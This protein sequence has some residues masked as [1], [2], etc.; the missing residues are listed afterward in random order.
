[1]MREPVIQVAAAIITEAGRI[2]IVQRPD[3]AQMGG[4]WEFPGGKIE[5][6]E[7][8]E[9]ALM[10]EIA[11]ELGIAISVGRL[12]HVTDYAYLAGPHV[13]LAFYDCQI[14]TGRPQLL[15]GQAFRWVTPADLPGFP[16]PAADRDV[17]AR[18]ST[19]RGTASAE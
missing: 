10:R 19:E 11:E 3:T 18:L 2:L 13:R 14:V 8:P 15:W 5:P 1:M 9:V 12:Y 17:V 6:G 16:T 4:L 7:T